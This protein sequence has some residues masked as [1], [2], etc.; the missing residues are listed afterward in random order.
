MYC[1]FHTSEGHPAV[2]VLAALLK[3]VVAGLEPI[4]SDIQNAFKRA[5]GQVDGRA[6]RLPGIRAM[7]TKSTSS[8]Q[9]VFI[10]IDALDEFP[11]KHRPGLWESLQHIVWT[12]P[13][14]RLFITGRPHI[15]DEVRK[16]FDGDF[17]TI[18]ANPHEEDIGTYLRK[19][20]E[21]DQHPDAM[22]KGLRDEIL[23]IIPERIS[24]VYVILADREFGIVS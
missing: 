24:E 13:N 10:C 20:L 7:L 14:A 9:R 11:P 5:K 6:L 23:K 2:S 22:D 15:L 19:R 16:Y 17:V 1:D 18:S 3:Q 4:P 21:E 8:L 12:C